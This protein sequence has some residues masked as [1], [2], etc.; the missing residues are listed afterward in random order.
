MVSPARILQKSAA[1]YPVRKISDRIENL[2]VGQA[3]RDLDG[4]HIRERYPQ[5]LGLPAR[6]APEQVR[7]TEKAGLPTPRSPSFSS[8]VTFSN[9]RSSRTLGSVCSYL[10]QYG[11]R[12]V[13]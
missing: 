7:V 1:I 3:G 5:V 13:G 9:F 4:T 12:R 11:P 6:V 10:Q 8:N 2:I